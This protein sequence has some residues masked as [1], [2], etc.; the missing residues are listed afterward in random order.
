[1]NGGGS[2]RERETQN[3]KQAPGSE[4]SAQSPT[5]GLNSR[6]A[7]SW[8][9]TKSDAQPTK[10]P[11]RPWP[12][13]FLLPFQKSSDFNCHS[14]SWNQI[15]VKVLPLVSFLSRKT[16]FLRGTPSRF[17]TSMYLCK[18]VGGAAARW[19]ATALMTNSS[20]HE[21]LEEQ[22]GAKTH[23]IIS[24]RTGTGSSIPGAMRLNSVA[25][26]SDL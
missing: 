12:S 10:P 4:L 21:P 7:R 8:P 14:D 5:R 23:N 2:E 11:R 9:E 3:L 17:P 15:P 19:P 22:R 24:Q 26:F 1:M 13:L 20:S 6:T 25:Q 18:K 16:Y